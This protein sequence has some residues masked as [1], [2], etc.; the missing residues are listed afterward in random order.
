MTGPGPARRGPGTHVAVR[1]ARALGCDFAPPRRHDPPSS[2]SR[3]W[4]HHLIER[5]Q[6][7]ADLPAQQPEAEEEARIPPPHAHPWGPCGAQESPLA[8]SRPPLGLIWRIRDHATFVAFAGAPPRRA[9]ALSVRRVDGPP[10]APPRVA[11]A[12][13]RRVGTAPV[14][15]RLR[16]RLRAVVAGLESELVPGSAYLIAARPEAVRMS[17]AELETALRQTFISLRGDA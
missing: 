17:T 10:D 13:G 15:N 3:P 6:R 4:A 8:G 2:A 11:Y 16:R 1:A 9:G 7:E 12:L 5:G 14:R